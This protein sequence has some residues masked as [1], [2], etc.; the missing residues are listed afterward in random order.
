[1]PLGLRCAAFERASG[2]LAPVSAAWMP[3]LS[4][5]FT[6]WF[7]CV[8][9]SAIACASWSRATAAAG[10]SATYFFIAAVS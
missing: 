5:F 6:R 8:E 7:S 10:N 2:D 3:S 4:A 9:N 1:M